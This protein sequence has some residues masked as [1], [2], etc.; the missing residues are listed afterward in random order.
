MRAIPPFFLS[1]RLYGPVLA[2]K[3][4][5]SPRCA[6]LTAPVRAWGLA[7][8]E[9]KGELQTAG[10]S[11]RTRLHKGAVSQHYGPGRAF[12]GLGVAKRYRRRDVNGDGFP[13]GLEP[14]VRE[15]GN[16]SAT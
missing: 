7:L 9:E 16:L 15:V 5:A 3:G 1:A 6:L 13:H 10:I 8:Y 2:V 14:R 4:S 11:T 12:K